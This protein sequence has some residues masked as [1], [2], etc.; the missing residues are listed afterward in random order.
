MSDRYSVD[1]SIK[2]WDDKRGDHIY[3]GP[4]R[5]G[6]GLLEIHRVLADG[7]SEGHLILTKEEAFLV[8]TAMQDMAMKLLAPPPEQD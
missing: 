3:V 2:I 7:T 1:H 4:D 5:D 6:L 8:A